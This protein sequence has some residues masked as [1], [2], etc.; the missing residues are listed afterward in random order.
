MATASPYKFLKAITSISLSIYPTIVA[1]RD[2]LGR[3]KLPFPFV[4]DATTSTVRVKQNDIS[5]LVEF[6]DLFNTVL[7]ESG[8]DVMKLG[9]FGTAKEVY[10]NHS[11][12]TEGGEESVDGLVKKYVHLEHKGPALTG[13]VV[14]FGDLCIISKVEVKQHLTLP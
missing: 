3:V 5:K 13:T 14:G 1:L 9:T 7:V 11:E 4:L 2:K 10:K 8:N 12:K 6:A